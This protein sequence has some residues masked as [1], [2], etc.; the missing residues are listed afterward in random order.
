MS[1]PALA[2]RRALIF[3][4]HN[5]VDWWR[6]LGLNMGWD[7]STVVTDLRGEGDISVVDD[8]Y[9][10]LKRTKRRP[11]PTF[12]LLSAAE[13]HDVVARCRTLRWIEPELAH[14]MIEAMAIALDRVLDRVAPRVVISFPIDRYVKH[15]LK[16][17]AARRCVQYLELT[18]SVVPSMSMLMR[19]GRLIFPAGDVAA[20]EVGRQIATLS[21]P[22]FA[23]SYVPG[24]STYTRVKF[25]RT[26][27]YLRTRAVAL[28]LISWWQRDPLNLHYLDAQPMLG[29]K[30]RWKDIRIIG[31]CDTHW[32]AKVEAVPRD[33]RALF[34]LQLFPEA[35]IDYWIA[36]LALID[37]ENLVVRAAK[38]FSDAGFV[39]MV[40][41]H[42][43]QFGCR[44]TELIDRL[45]ALPGAVI[46][47]Y[48]V[49]GNELLALAGV[50]FT[51][52]GTMGLQAALQGVKS[53]VT[54]SYYSNDEDFIVFRSPREVDTL[55]QRVMQTDLTTQPLEQRQ[56]RMIGQLL[57]GSFDGDFF[58]FKGFTRAAPTPGA[59]NLARALGQR[60]DMLA[61][62]GSI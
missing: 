60:L 2:G 9:A 4:I 44:Q 54:D 31:L 18:A 32:R 45:R 21:S 46:V 30:G 40:K 27:S 6:H 19:D 42:P 26:F 25:L 13:K 12:R 37:H 56:R 10:E 29:H 20:A 62:Q 15:L 35:S 28:K 47:P 38:A 17:L 58:S 53:V 7:A 34:G 33:R 24:K 41:D 61:A 52:T 22:S 11:D 50:N 49:S 55:P 48:E 51:C 8:F 16:L 36:N 57:I 23:P 39:V 14:A 1:P 43:L 5:T 59:D 3:G